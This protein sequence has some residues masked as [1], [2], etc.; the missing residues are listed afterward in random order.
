MIYLITGT[1]GTGKTSY[2]LKM[3]LDNKFDLFKDEEG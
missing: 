2:A 1:P 3:I